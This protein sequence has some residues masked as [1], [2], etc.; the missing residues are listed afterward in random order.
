M[1]DLINQEVMELWEEFYPENTEILSPL[2]YPEQPKD[3]FLFIGINP[4]F[5]ESGL[6][7]ILKGTK[8]YDEYDI[9]FFKW[10]N[11]KYFVLSDAAEIEKIAQEKYPYFTRPKQLASEFNLEMSHVDLFFYREKNQKELKKHI[12]SDLKNYELNDFGKKQINLSLRLIELLQPRIILVI[13]ALACRLFLKYFQP[14]EDPNNGCHYLQVK[15]ESIPVFFSSMLSGQRALD[16]F[17]YSRLK[18]HINYIYNKKH[19]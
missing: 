18:W 5:N 1:I 8:Y 15:G 11:R 14:D 13:N 17:S 12:F 7:T 6:K 16:D 4:S 19:T 3:S 9:E 2:I 10:C